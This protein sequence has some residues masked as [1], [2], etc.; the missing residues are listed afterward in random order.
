LRKVLDFHSYCG[1]KR[2]WALEILGTVYYY[3][4][5]PA[6]T[7]VPG[8]FEKY[9]YPSNMYNFQRNGK[10]SMILE[11]NPSGEVKRA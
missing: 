8:R 1:L 6:C 2:L 5:V 3:K 10:D 4:F 9:E 11:H 7:K